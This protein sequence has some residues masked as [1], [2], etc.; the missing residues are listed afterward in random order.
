MSRHRLRASRSPFTPVA[1]LGLAAVLANVQVGCASSTDDVPE[2]QD[3]ARDAGSDLLDGDRG[4]TLDAAG[5]AADSDGDACLDLCEPNQRRCVAGDEEAVEVC[6]ADLDGCWD[7]GTPAAC[8]PNTVCRE[9]TCEPE[10]ISDPGCETTSDFRCTSASGFSQCEEQAPGCLRYGEE[11]PCPEFM[12]CAVGE[13]CRCQH[14]CEERGET[15]CLTD[16]QI[17]ICE[18]TENGCLVWSPPS[19]CPDSAT[20]SDGFCEA[21]C[22]SDSG[23][24]EAGLRRCHSADHYVEC[25]EVETDCFQWSDPV[26]CPGTLTCT[27]GECGTTCTSD[28]DE[29][30]ELTCWDDFAQQSCEEFQPGCLKWTA[31]SSCPAHQEC[32][33][34]GTG[35][36]CTDPCTLGDSTCVPDTEPSLVEICAEDAAG[37]LFFDYDYCGVDQIC[38]SGECITACLSDPGCSSAGL[39]DCFSSSAVMTCE[40][41]ETDCF[42]WGAPV[43]CPAHQE[44]QAGACECIA[45]SG[46]TTAGDRRCEDAT[47][48]AVCESDAAGCRFWD[49]PV[50]CPP[51][52][53]CSGGECSLT[54]TSDPGCTGPGVARCTETGA[55]QLCVE[56]ESGCF[57]WGT[58]SS[59]ADDHVCDEGAGCVCRVDCDLDDTRCNAAGELE[60]CVAAGDCN[61]WAAESCGGGLSC[62]LDACIAVQ[63]PEVACGQVTFNLVDRGFSEAYVAGELN[64]WSEIDTPMSLTDGIWWATH[65]F[66]TPGQYEYKLVI[67]GV[68]QLDPLNPA[69]AGE[70]FFT[71]NVVVVEHV[72]DCTSLSET[73][74]SEAGSLEA[75]TDVDGCATWQPAPD[76]CLDDDEYCAAGV[77]EPL[78]SPVVEADQITFTT[79]DRGYAGV[80]VAGTFT[81]PA[82]SVDVLL[83]ALEGRFSATLAM[84]DYPALTPG[85]H[86]Y[87]F[88]TS[89][90]VW[91][92]DP[93]NPD[94][95]DDTVGGLN[96][97]FCISECKSGELTC[98]DTLDAEAT[99]ELGDY[100]CHWW[101]Y[102][103]CSLDPRQHC[104]FDV[105]Q[106][107]P[108]VDEET[109]VV[110]FYLVADS[111][112]RV[113]V[114]GDFTST[115]WSVDEALEMT[116][117]GDLWSAVSD[118]LDPGS[119]A[120]KFLI[121]PGP[122]ETWLTDPLNPDDTGEPDFNSIVDVP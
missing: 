70:G 45:V 92:Y 29:V 23:C 50:E 122:G 21:G 42:Q 43:S 62:V 57:K 116:L 9:G 99:C 114:A 88:R 103:D 85:V 97:V 81:D 28:C 46:C 14:R 5:D 86:E 22:V 95:V 79:R 121:D 73:R 102:S 31:P 75:C 90:G 69:T 67:D 13:G 37:C 61:A 32:M 16:T 59:C 49:D 76:P 108:E 113:L 107:F 84:E 10:C 38:E 63:S 39:T 66:D 36:D 83:D 115:A 109:G 53:T 82:W 94:T 60:R 78:V 20:C 40:E 71:N 19:V 56:V 27:A 26:R 87:K 100:G 119:Y 41:V 118:P 34:G 91:F 30:G 48:Y 24:T 64:D 74:C 44:C 12:V 7:W 111:E 72:E 89:G 77:C 4:D 120:Y 58:P 55:E 80:V 33:G 25:L 65:T 1:V 17:Q 35:C 106:S 18:R 54:C 3:G 51:D 96:S 110:T 98:A 104:L 47:H 105:C 117:A 8:P 52:Q 2:A 6:R 93:A 101:S 68:W 112:S 15:R 11:Q